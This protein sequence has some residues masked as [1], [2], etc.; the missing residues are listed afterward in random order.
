MIRKMFVWSSRRRTAD[1]RGDHRPRWYSALVPKSMIAVTPKTAQ[2]HLAV[3]V[4]D[5]T[6]RTIDA[7]TTNGVTPR[8]IQP[9][10]CGLTASAALSTTSDR[11]ASDG[12]E[13]GAGEVLMA[14]ISFRRA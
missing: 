14:R 3:G 5:S 4:G 9:R 1:V 10:R 8:W 2:D 13:A 11:P 7:T 6:T 12:P